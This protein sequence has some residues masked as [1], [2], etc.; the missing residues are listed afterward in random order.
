M[1]NMGDS[2]RAN[3]LPTSGEKK[4]ISDSELLS[5]ILKLLKARDGK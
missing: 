2:I 4:Q 3:F 5:E 1:D